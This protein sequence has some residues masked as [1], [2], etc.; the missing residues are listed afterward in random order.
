MSSS[1]RRGAVLG[2]DALAAFGAAASAAWRPHELPNADA[3][4]AH[5]DLPP[6]DGFGADPFGA[7]A[8]EQLAPAPT[9]WGT[10]AGFAD[11]LPDFLDETNDDAT[12]AGLAPE[13]SLARE[14]A[15]RDDLVREFEAQLAEI[16]ARHEQ[17][18]AEA[19]AAGAAE[20]QREGAAAAERR[21]APAIGALTEARDQLAALEDRWLATSTRTSP[22]WRWASPATSSA[23]RSAPTTRWCASAS[24][25]RSPSTRWIRR[26]A[27]A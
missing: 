18:L 8:L 16:A 21:L 3:A 15:L 26:S 4:F 1:D 27:C 5:A 10:D 11:A 14:R 22:C 24:P 23:A 13:L 12:R 17:E 20:G 6:A 19:Y 25:P 7:F 2:P 9:A